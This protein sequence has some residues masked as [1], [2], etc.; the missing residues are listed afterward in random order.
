MPDIGSSGIDPRTTGFERFRNIRDRF[1]DAKTLL[2]LGAMRGFGAEI[3]DCFSKHCADE[4]RAPVKRTANEFEIKNN[5]S[6]RAQMKATKQAA[7]MLADHTKNSSIEEVIDFLNKQSATKAMLALSFLRSAESVEAKNIHPT[8]IRRLVEGED[9]VTRLS[10]P[11]KMEQFDGYEI[12]SNHAWLYDNRV[13]NYLRFLGALPE[14]EYDEL[15][16]REMYLFTNNSDP[17]QFAHHLVDRDRISQNQVKI[18]QDKEIL[19]IGPGNGADVELFVQNAAANVTVLDGSHFIIDR[20]QKRYRENGLLHSKDNPSGKVIV[21]NHGMDMRDALLHY[22]Q[23]GKKFDTICAHSCLHYFDDEELQML[24]VLL[25]DSLRQ[26]GHLV[27][28]VK[29]PG[30]TMDGNGIKIFEKIEER[31]HLASDNSV[32]ETTQ[33]V[34]GRMWVNL[35]GQTRNFRSIDAWDDLLQSR[36]TFLE[37]TESVIE[38]YEAP[39]VSQQFFNFIYRR[40]ETGLPLQV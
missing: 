18:I 2:H 10:L 26:D 20:L 37:K 11:G 13:L 3:A 4:T 17:T 34:R 7:S 15:H 36:F 22:Q 32:R 12:G 27:F 31:I 5:V 35:D 28:A 29:A 19:E 23:Q 8:N 25:H 40:K 38:S 24:L 1:S 9:E 30:A 16:K 6:S 39:G 14:I 33:D 21:P